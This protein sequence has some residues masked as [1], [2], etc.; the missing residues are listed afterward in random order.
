MRRYCILCASLVIQMCLGGIYAW[1]SFIPTLTAD[2]GLSITSLQIV[3]GFTIAFFTITMVFAGRFSAKHG[4]NVT[5]AIGGILLGTGY[6]LASLS[7]GAFVPILLGIGVISGAGIGF[8]YVCPLAICIQWFPRHKGLI[9][10][11]AVAGFGGGAIMLSSI[12]G[13]LLHNGTN[14]LTVFRWIGL[15][16]AAIIIPSAILLTVPD[17]FQKHFV[18][19]DYKKLFSSSV[20]WILS[21]GLFSGTF[22]GL[23]V[24]GNL[25]PIG[26]SFSVSLYSAN[27]AIST[28]AIGNALG[29]IIWGWIIDKIG[30]AA[31]PLSLLAL[32]LALSSLPISQGSDLLFIII[33]ALIGFGYG[34]CFVIYAAQTAATFGAE[35][36]SSIYPLIFLAYGISGLVGPGVGGAIY[37]LSSSYIPSVLAASFICAISAV[38][39]FRYYQGKKALPAV[40]PT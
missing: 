29:R 40:L 39:I 1:S 12:A 10:G 19:I 8:S 25:K 23:L 31:V 18:K 14:V 11:I 24:I 38:I 20:F 32:C 21:L 22:A 17:K 33:M 30:N 28:F 7:K 9:T 3:F 6:I 26:I 5:A 34:G 13:C 15:I 16:Y 37:D 4:Y 2:Y 35:A 27:L 36:V